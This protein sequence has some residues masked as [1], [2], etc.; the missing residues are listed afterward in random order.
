MTPGEYGFKRFMELF[1]SD[2]EAM[3]FADIPADDRL[4][5]EILAKELIEGSW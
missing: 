1:A 4:D 2:E 5:W 3:D